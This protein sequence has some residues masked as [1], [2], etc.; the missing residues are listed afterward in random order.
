MHKL[1]TTT[2]SWDSVFTDYHERKAKDVLFHPK[3]IKVITIHYAFGLTPEMCFSIFMN[4]AVFNKML[5][6]YVL[7]IMHIVCTICVILLSGMFHTENM[8]DM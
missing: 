6:I 4:W 8:Q 1:N 7:H 3:N 2:A 5:T